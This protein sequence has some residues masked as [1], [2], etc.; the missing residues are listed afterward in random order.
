[1]SSP[2]QSPQLIIL[3][4]ILSP[5]NPYHVAAQNPQTPRQINNPPDYLESLL[6][7]EVEGRVINNGGNIEA[8]FRIINQAH[9]EVSARKIAR[10]YINAAYNS[11]RSIR[12][13]KIE[14]IQ[15]SGGIGL[16]ITVGANI[17][18][19]YKDTNWI[20]PRTDPSVFIRWVKHISAQ[21]RGLG[22]ER[23]SL[24]NAITI[25]G[26]WSEL[27]PQNSV[28]NKPDTVSVQSVRDKESQPE[29]EAQ[30]A[31]SARNPLTPASRVYGTEQSVKATFQER[32]T[33]EILIRKPIPTVPLNVSL[34]PTAGP[35]S[36][37]IV[38]PKASHGEDKSLGRRAT[39]KATLLNTQPSTLE[40]RAPLKNKDTESLPAPVSQVNDFASVVDEMTKHTLETLLSDL[41]QRAGINLTVVTV[42][43][44]AG[45]D[46]FDFS[47]QLAR[48]WDTGA[49]TSASKSFLLVVAVDEKAFFT[50]FS[51]RAQTALPDGAL[52]EMNRLMRPAIDAGRISE[53]LLRGIQSFVVVLRQKVGDSEEQAR[54]QETVSAKSA[55]HIRTAAREQV[56]KPS[57]SLV[58]YSS[59]VVP[60]EPG[61]LDHAVPVSVNESSNLTSVEPEG[62]AATKESST[63]SDSERAARNED[64]NAADRSASDAPSSSSSAN[65]APPKEVSLTDIYRIGV[66]DVLDIRLLNS[67]Y[68]RSTLYNV[69][70]GGLIDLPI[71]GGPIAVA[72][73]TVDEIQVR[74][75]SELKRR[76]IEEGARVSVGVRHYASHSVVITGLVQNPGS[77]ILRREAVPLYIIMAEAQARPDAGRIT[78][79]RQGSAG[80]TVDLNDEGALNLIIQPGDTISVTARPQEFYYIAGAINYP[81]Q[82]VFKP[83]VTLLQAIFAAGGFRRQGD[84]RIDLW[85]EGQNGR[86][87]ATTF[88]WKEI[89]AGKIQDPRLQPGDR[90]EVAY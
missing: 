45:Q 43:T 7:E 44:T 32:R 78:I 52:G 60:D 3:L 2:A 70:D 56:R 83:G 68:S 51:R 59:S 41:K 20:D 30:G 31:K 16:S 75:A 8:R 50:Q 10:D 25:E 1:M 33:P 88:K 39:V 35:L 28:N 76:A 46:I 15:P 69:I 49:P 9:P 57:G 13:A 84:N 90:I 37:S 62:S 89:R 48:Y 42:H 4:I 80:P 71:A 86:L 85:R 81:G 72:G 64:S 82:K 26:P 73:L 29:A 22:L 87:A 14:I 58:A 53:G 34:P 18:S 5:F 67:A 65:P 47:R 12:S 79:M 61:K 17:A 6:P 38:A 23:A 11:G 54:D 27:T 74:V 77:K 40:A 36:P 55:A 66:G 24:K 21:Q 63:V 19:V